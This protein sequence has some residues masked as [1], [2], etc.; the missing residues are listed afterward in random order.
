MTILP[1]IHDHV[2]DQFLAFQAIDLTYTE[3]G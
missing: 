2:S 1:F 3:I